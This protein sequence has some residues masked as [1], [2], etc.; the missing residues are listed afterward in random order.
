MVDTLDGALFDTNG[1][2]SIATRSNSGNLSGRYYAVEI[3]SGIDNAGYV[4]TPRSI[5][6]WLQGGGGATATSFGGSPYLDIWNGSKPGQTIAAATAS[7]HPK[8]PN[9]N[10]SYYKRLMTTSKPVVVFASLG[11]NQT[12]EVEAVWNASLDSLKAKLDERYPYAQQVYLTQNPQLTGAAYARHHNGPRRRELIAWTRRNSVG[13]IDVQGVF[14]G[15]GLA[16][17]SLVH[18]ENPPGTPDRV[19]P[20]TVGSVLWRDAVIA[21]YEGGF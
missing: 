13:C 2:Y 4:V 5:D 8:A 6:A 11:H 12:N 10:V 14:Y 7:T 20:T 17:T 15:S 1:E 16:L 3:R 21:A 19:H 9:P 18:Q